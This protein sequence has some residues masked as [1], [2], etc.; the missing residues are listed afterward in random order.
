MEQITLI[1][2]DGTQ[3]RLFNKEPFTTV[4]MA[5][6]SKSLMSID[7]V[8]LTIQST[9]LIDFEKGD[10]IQVYGYD[11]YIRT[12][13]NRELTSDGSF[14]YEATFYGLL[15]DL[16]KTPYR[17]MDVNGKSSSNTFDLVYTL[18]EFIRVLINNVS[19]DYPGLWSFDE[20]GCPDKD[21]KLI[22]FSCN[23]C[24]EVL[25]NVCKTFDVD[26][27]IIQ[28][29]GVRY[30]KIGSFG[31]VVSPPDGSSY[32]EWGRGNGL[33]S[34]KENK[35][36]DQSVKT[37]IWAEG[38]TQNLPTN[39]R[40]YAQRLQLPYP[41]RLN[42]R[43]HTLYDGTVVAVGSMTIGISDDKKRYV[44]DSTLSDLI[45]VDAE[46]K[47]FDDI[48]PTRT[49]TVSAIDAN[50]VFSFFDSSMDFDLNE[51]VDGNTKYLINGTSAK[52]T[53]VSGK[54]AGQQF[55][56]SAYSHSTKKFTL[57][58]YQDE[59]GLVLPTQDSIAYRIAVGD[60][61]KITDIVMPDAIIAA[62]E[63]DLWFAAYDYLLQVRQPRV[64]YSLVIDRMR[65]LEYALSDSQALFT[66]GDYVPVKDTRFGVQKN[67]SIQKV[68]R[69]LLLKHDYTLTISDTATIAPITKAIIELEK[70]NMILQSNNLVDPVRARRSWRTTEELRQMVFDTDGFFDMGNIRPES[71]DTNM[72]TVGSKSQQFILEGVLIEP[73]YGSN[74]NRIKVSAHLTISESSFRT[75]NMSA[76]DL[77]L[78]ET[79]GY[80]MYAKCQK[81]SQAGVWLITQT[82]YKFEP[83][84]DQWKVLE[85]I[86]DGIE[87]E[88]NK[89]EE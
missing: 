6:Q 77:T 88:R 75:W 54:L 12:A 81:N 4:K 27:Q 39:Y 1:K 41:Q 14:K 35:V 50:D 63:E 51:K 33:Y 87:K 15:Y 34:L 2:R 17:D 61:Y 64:Q 36:N 38:G 3:I 70:H 82:Q 20:V 7:T 5:T 16:M 31:S 62:A 49:G 21:P 68:E 22:Q 67:I 69:N 83:D 53:F 52:I 32:F 59:R 37:R 56:L 18:K 47:L 25:Q 40:E 24:L 44:E 58:P 43:Q 28:S 86:F 57:L 65:L 9:Q 71:V 73:N 55:E 45:G 85:Q 46:S 60:K 42:T 89:K 48:Y 10:K 13:V 78:G 74:P 23:N 76:L 80:Y 30:I 29:Q 66:P 26:F 8:T 11:Y 79:S 19:Q 72:L 84:S